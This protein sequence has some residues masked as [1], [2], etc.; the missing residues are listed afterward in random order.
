MQGKVA[1]S[2]CCICLV[3]LKLRSHY[4][5]T[6]IQLNFYFEGERNKMLYLQ[7]HSNTPA[8]G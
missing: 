5:Q 7:V 2:M 6:F 8:Y 1:I 4:L 3:W